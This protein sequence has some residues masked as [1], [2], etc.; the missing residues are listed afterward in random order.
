MGSSA[1]PV[2]RRLVELGV[3][4]RPTGAY[5]RREML[6]RLDKSVP[7]D[8]R[9][10]VEG[11]FHGWLRLR[12]FQIHMAFPS[13]RAT[14][15]YLE[16]SPATL[17][18]QIKQLEAAIGARLL[19]RS[20]PPVPHQATSAG[21]SLLRHL[22]EEHV[23]ELMHQALGTA[24]TPLPTKDVLADAALTFG[25]IEAPLS[26]LPPGTEVPV[27]LNVPASLLPLL[28]HLFHDGASGTYVAEIHAATGIDTGTIYAQLR[29]LKDA[30]WLESQRELPSNR[31]RRPGNSL[32]HYSLTPAARLIPGF[33]DQ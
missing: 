2:R 20:A 30:G 4:L 14:A 17:T 24:I 21:A 8:I 6:A 7:A 9:A 28:R 25:G 5:S 29:R 18:K 15:A 27:H 3:P 11:T 1:G 33:G 13:L 32:V 31:T 10:A 12:R 16:T 19:T 23:Q 22:D 26:R